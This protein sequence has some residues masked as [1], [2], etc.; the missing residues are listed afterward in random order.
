VAE[1]GEKERGKEKWKMK[2]KMEKRKRGKRE[3]LA[4]RQ[5]VRLF[6]QNRSNRIWGPV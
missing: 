3:R 5:E 4:R 2:R 6:G 1:E